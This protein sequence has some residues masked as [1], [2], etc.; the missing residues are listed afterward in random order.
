M[1]VVVVVR[2][3]VVVVGWGA[4]VAGVVGEVVAGAVVVVGQ[5]GRR[6]G[7]LVDA[8]AGGDASAPGAVNMATTTP[9]APATAAARLAERRINFNLFGIRRGGRNA[10]PR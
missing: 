9:A 6:Q 8:A 7:A 3:L 1:V 10:C 4:V 2:G 5:G